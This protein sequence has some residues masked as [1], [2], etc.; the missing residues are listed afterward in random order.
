MPDRASR[1][2][3]FL[4]L[5]AQLQ[6]PETI[7][8]ARAVPLLVAEG[9]G[10]ISSV[11]AG[12]A[13]W[14]AGDGPEMRMCHLQETPPVEHVCAYAAA[15][16][17]ALA[18]T[19]LSSWHGDSFVRW[20]IVA[21]DG[22]GAVA[23]IDVKPDPGAGRADMAR[24]SWLAAIRALGLDGDHLPPS[25][26]TRSDE[27]MISFARDRESMWC[28]RRRDLPIERPNYRYL[29]SSLTC[30]PHY[31]APV[32]ELFRRAGEALVGSGGRWET[33]RSV[34]AEARTALEAVVRLRPRDHVAWT[35]LGMLNRADDRLN[36]AREGLQ[37]AAALS[38]DYSPAHRELGSVLL[39]RGQLRQAGAHLRK[40]GALSPRDPEV[41]LYL[42]ALYVA[43]SQRPSAT[44]HLRAVL[45]LA[46]GTRAAGQAA[47]LLRD[48]DEGPVRTVT[49]PLAGRAATRSRQEHHRSR[50]RALI[51]H[52]F[53]FSDVV[54]TRMAQVSLEIDES[55]DLDVTFTD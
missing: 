41:H 4:P 2:V 7:A 49:N 26:E 11:P 6:D 38:P 34:R 9:L 40:A 36:A 3:L 18:F 39:D 25:L 48:L 19:G 13:I 23:R 8:W 51:A 54:P 47:R 50:D 55:F 52:T 21:M 46:P 20:D 12:F 44:D 27:A 5:S 43:T 30:D 33:G 37:K 35:L 22:R 29:L 14:T 53:D 45:K 32:L 28:R 42:G 31:K 1:S 17:A 10:D 24:A 15:A 16:G